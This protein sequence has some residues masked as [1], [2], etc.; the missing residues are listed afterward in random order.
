MASSRSHFLVISAL[1]YE[2]L[3]KR[4][5]GPHRKQESIKMKEDFWVLLSAAIAPTIMIV[6]T[7]RNTAEVLHD[8]TQWQRGADY[9]EEVNARAVTA[10]ALTP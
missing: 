3:I 10:D 2:R 8:R 9:K 4:D 5:Q 6:S 1:H 7:S